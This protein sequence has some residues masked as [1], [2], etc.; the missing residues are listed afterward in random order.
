MEIKSNN[1]LFVRLISQL[2][3]K[4]TLL[5]IFILQFQFVSAYKTDSISSNKVNENEAL[6]KYK[7][8]VLDIYQQ[9]QDLGLY[10]LESDYKIF[11]SEIEKPNPNIDLL[12]IYADKFKFYHKLKQEESSNLERIS[13]EY[14]KLSAKVFQYKN[15]VQ[16]Q[17]TMSKSSGTFYGGMGDEEHAVILKKRLLEAGMMVFDANMQA[18]K[19]INP[20]NQIERIEVLN[21]NMKLLKKMEQ[22]SIA[23][24]TRS[25]EKSLKNIEDIEKIKEL[26]YEY[27]IN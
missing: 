24:N 8:E 7:I 17:F 3:M 13:D 4:Y 21:D 14:F 23:N 15:R 19:Y 27:Q 18:V 26:I 12:K 20:C 22:L 6:T 9:Y 10:T 16:Q 25:L 11:L 5:S 2:F 1:N